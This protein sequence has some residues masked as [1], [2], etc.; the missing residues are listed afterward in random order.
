VLV[1]ISR[2]YIQCVS[3]DCLFLVVITSVVVY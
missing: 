1:L 2:L 3:H